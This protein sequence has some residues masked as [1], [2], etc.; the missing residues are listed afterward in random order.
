M[1]CRDRPASSHPSSLRHHSCTTYSASFMWLLG[2]QIQVLTLARQVPVDQIISPIP[3]ACHFCC[4]TG[5]ARQT[6]TKT[7]SWVGGIESVCSGVNLR[8]S[9]LVMLL[10]PW[11]AALGSDPGS[12]R[13]RPAGFLCDHTYS[14]L[15]YSPTARGLRGQ[16]SPFLQEGN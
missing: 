3:G 9:Q 4:Q 16:R 6:H 5:T 1:T 15:T 8:S 12:F 2:I 11:G 13:S 7:V 10:H 14:P